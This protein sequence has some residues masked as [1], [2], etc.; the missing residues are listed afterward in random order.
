M[1]RVE[2]LFEVVADDYSEVWING[3][4]RKS[5]GHGPTRHQRLQ[6]PAARLAHRQ[7]QPGDTFDLAILVTNGPIADLP[8]NYVW[9]RSATLDFYAT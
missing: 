7:R 2:V 5:F 8:D 9:I 6:C 4:L 3:K 1:K